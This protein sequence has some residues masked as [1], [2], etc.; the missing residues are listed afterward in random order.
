ML[1]Y[2]KKNNDLDRTLFLTRHN[3]YVFIYF[4]KYLLLYLT[5]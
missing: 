4:A 3:L 1:E 2:W 5:L